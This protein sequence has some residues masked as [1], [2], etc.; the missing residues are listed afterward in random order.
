MSDAIV[1]G[2]GVIGLA[3]AH[4]LLR[5]GAQ[6]TL[7]ERD[8]CGREASWAGGG[9]LL[10]LMP[11]DYA[12]PV[13]RLAELSG[14]LYP[15]FVHELQAGTGL[16]PEFHAS[17]MLVLPDSTVGEA[18]APHSG[19]LDADMAW[20]D[21]HGLTAKQVSARRIAP[22]LASEQTGLWLPGVC[23]VR[24][25]RLLQALAQAVIM[26]GGVIA[27][28]EEVVEWKIANGRIRAVGTQGGREYAADHYIVAA[29]A[30]SRELLSGHA[31]QLRIH[32][33]RGQILLFKGQ[34][35]LL[36]VIVLRVSD[37]L[38][39]IPRRDGHILAGSTLEEAGFDKRTTADAREMLLSKA[40]GLL[41]ALTE[42]LVAGQ[43][44]GLRPGSPGNM[45]VIARHPRIPN[46]Y[47]NSGHHRYGVTM[48][49][50][51][52]RLLC[53]LLLG[54]PQPLDVAPYRWPA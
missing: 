40:A 15:A 28:R 50:A 26:R 12:E 44:A 19:R 6:V 34:P 16:D 21:R 29:G 39:L 52:A 10:P 9:I 43:W 51:S 23:Q 2:G 8:R 24:N 4:E 30:W 46:L 31:L 3:T 37:N 35:G 20:C 54:R 17:G 42:S 32:P 1:V 5:Q 18:A 36:P 11:W 47:L 49:P 13:V 45:P 33:V 41:P 27:E 7:L 14:L 38:Y 25:P 48:A 22:A 53:N